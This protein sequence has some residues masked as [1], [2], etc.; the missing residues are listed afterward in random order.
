MDGD[1]ILTKVLAEV[2]EIFDLASTCFN[3][4]IDNELLLLYLSIGLIG[5]GLAVFRKM[6]RTVRG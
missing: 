4:V 2:P 3:E 5:A 1:G 6:R